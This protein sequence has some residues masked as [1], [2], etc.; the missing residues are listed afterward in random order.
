MLWLAVFLGLGACLAA[1]AVW[2][3]LDFVFQSVMT[4]GQDTINQSVTVST[5]ADD[6]VYSSFTVPA[7]AT[8]NYTGCAGSPANIKGISILTTATMTLTVNYASGADDTFTL[9][10]NE[11]L[12]WHNKMNLSDPFVN[13]NAI[14]SMD[15]NNATAADGTVTIM[16]ARDS[17]S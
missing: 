13:T 6:K 1:L 4:H 14:T 3:G 11:P 12:T 16:I 5:N 17:T 2:Q 8:V 10:A 15:F 9:T 7:S